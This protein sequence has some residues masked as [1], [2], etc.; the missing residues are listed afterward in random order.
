MIRSAPI[1]FVRTADHPGVE[2][3]AAQG[4]VFEALDYVYE[5]AGTFEEVYARIVERM[6]AEAVERREVVY[7]VTTRTIPR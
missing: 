7:A 6:L 4:V 5:S 2:E 1:V 3:L